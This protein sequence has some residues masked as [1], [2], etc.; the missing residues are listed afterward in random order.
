MLACRVGNFSDGLNFGKAMTGS[1]SPTPSGVY[2]MWPDFDNSIFSA[3]SIDPTAGL[4]TWKRRNLTISEP[5]RVGKWSSRSTGFRDPARAFEYPSGSDQWWVTVGCGSAQQCNSCPPSPQGCSG[6][7][8]VVSAQVRSDT[9]AT[10]LSVLT[11]PP[12]RVGVPLFFRHACSRPRTTRSQTLQTQVLST[13]RISLTVWWITT[14][15]GSR[16]TD[17]L[18]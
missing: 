18:A 11:L 2:A 9:R 6:K 7:S 4:Q 15:S 3:K 12:L 14:L 16:R 17:L 10:R 5:T 13:P 8:C 1:V